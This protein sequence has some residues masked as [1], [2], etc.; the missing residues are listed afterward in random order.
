M[1][2]AEL[3]TKTGGGGEWNCEWSEVIS[4]DDGECHSRLSTRAMPQ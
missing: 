3:Q 1:D 4:V 2:N